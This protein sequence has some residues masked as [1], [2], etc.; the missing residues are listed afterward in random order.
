RDWSVTGV[1]TYAL[2]ISHSAEIFQAQGRLALR[3]GADIIA[4]EC[5]SWTLEM[6]LDG[7]LNHRA[8]AWN[9]ARLGNHR[10]TADFV[11]NLRGGNRSEE[12]RVGDGAGARGG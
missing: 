8:R 3:T 6:V 7:S 2:P 11:T 10:I 5:G 9:A 12:R 1:Q 4:A